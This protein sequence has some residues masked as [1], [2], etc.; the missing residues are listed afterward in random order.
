M[1]D[2]GLIGPR[3]Q[4]TRP[5]RTLA[6]ASLS[7][8]RPQWQGRP[9]SIRLPRLARYRRCHGMAR[10]V[11]APSPSYR[12]TIEQAQ[13]SADRDRYPSGPVGEFVAKLVQRLLQQEESQQPL[14][15]TGIGGQ[16]RTVADPC[17]VGVHEPRGH[18]VG[19]ADEPAGFGAG[20]HPELRTG[21]RIGEGAQ[22]AGYVP[23]RRV[24]ATPLVQRTHRLAF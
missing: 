16:A 21:R 4:T 19:P 12:P 8:M 10:I 1:Q 22:H 14:A 18:R 2:E 20:G 13:N 3:N 5:Y 17:P 15:I 6:N 24:L 7:A 23:E 11:T 9:G